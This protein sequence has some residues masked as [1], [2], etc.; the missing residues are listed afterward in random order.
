[1]GRTLDGYQAHDHRAAGVSLSLRAA[2]LVLITM[3]TGMLTALPAIAADAA[4]PAAPSATAGHWPSVM[5]T[6]MRSSNLDRSIRF[7]TE[8]LGM[9]VLTTRVSGPVTEVIF[10]FP[11]SP[12]HPG[13]MVFQKKGHGESLPVDH[14][15]S[16]TKVVLGVADIA[17]IAKQL[18][19]AGYPVGEVQAHGPYKVL[20]IQ[21][22]DG[23]QFEVVETPESRQRH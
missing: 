16:E 6:G 15:N 9:T 4:S 23:Y 18:A 8:G 12:D 21:D 11:N 7:Y 5:S 19:A 10:G 22:P 3:A 1:M 20:W 13:L 2:V 17:A 14:G